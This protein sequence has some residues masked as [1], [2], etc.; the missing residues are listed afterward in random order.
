MR[1][2]TSFAILC[3]ISSAVAIEHQHGVEPGYHNHIEAGQHIVP[4]CLDCI[5]DYS[6]DQHVVRDHR[7][8]PNIPSSEYNKQV[9]QFEENDNVFDQKEYEVRVQNEAKLMIALEALKSSVT[10]I[11]KDIDAVR[12]QGLHTRDVLLNSTTSNSLTSGQDKAFFTSRRDRLYEE[13][14]YT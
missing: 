5:D 10:L 13:C 8:N 4:H 6:Y 7:S 14:A 2:F 11:R 12:D 1:H 3:A 9:Y